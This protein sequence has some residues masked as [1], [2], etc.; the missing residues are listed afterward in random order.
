MPL[1]V[2][3]D[4]V[5]ALDYLTEEQKISKGSRGSEINRFSLEVEI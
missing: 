4:S 1:Q 3:W 2:S 5:P